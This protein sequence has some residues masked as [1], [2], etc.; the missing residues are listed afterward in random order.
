MIEVVALYPEAG[1]A[2]SKRGLRRLVVAPYPYL[3]FYRIT[4]DAI[5]IHGV[6]HTG[7]KPMV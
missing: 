2:T 7:R 6:R 5:V 3:V 4:G 1:Q